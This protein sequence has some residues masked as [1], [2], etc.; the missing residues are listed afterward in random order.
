MKQQ[1]YLIFSSFTVYF[2]RAISK[3][4]DRDKVLPG[5]YMVTLHSLP[6][7]VTEDQ[8]K[9]FLFG[10]KIQHISIDE[11]IAYKTLKPILG[12]RINSSIRSEKLN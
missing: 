7:T 10:S 9:D 5:D 3:E 6:W 12:P 2:R 11:G 8:I 4:L 1:S